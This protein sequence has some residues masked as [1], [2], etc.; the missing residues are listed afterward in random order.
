MIEGVVRQ[1]VWQVE[2]KVLNGMVLGAQV[3]KPQGVG[4]EAGKPAEFELIAVVATRGLGRAQ[5]V[6][7][8][9]LVR[10]FLQNI[11]LFSSLTRYG[12]A[13]EIILQF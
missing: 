10:T 4:L 3:E 11:Y 1:T 13:V 2:E 9:Q 5:R 8:R 7:V 6:V 12:E